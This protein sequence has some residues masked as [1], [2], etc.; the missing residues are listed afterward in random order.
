M[1]GHL[2][3]GWIDPDQL[4][5]LENEAKKEQESEGGWEGEEVGDPYWNANDE[6]LEQLWLESQ[7][8]SQ[9]SQQS[10]VSMMDEE[11]YGDEFGDDYDDASF[12]EALARLPV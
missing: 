10:D 12:E 7:Q 2:E 1:K 8:Q 3:I 11:R 9:A 4:S 5:W 6:E